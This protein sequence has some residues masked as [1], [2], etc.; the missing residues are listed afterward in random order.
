MAFTGFEDMNIWKTAM[1]VATSV[2]EITVPLPRSE[3]YGLTSQI[4][5]SALSISANIA[6]GFGRSSNLDKIKFY[7]YSRGSAFEIKNH[8][9]YGKRVAYFN[10]KEVQEIANNIDSIIFEL[11]KIMKSLK[12]HSQSQPQSQPQ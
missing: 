10:E 8:L 3:D 6:E 12:P 11:N 1:N 5:R 7:I 2:F 9:I 4:R